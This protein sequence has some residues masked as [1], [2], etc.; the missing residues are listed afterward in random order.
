MAK[1]MTTSPVFNFWVTFSSPK[2]DQKDEEETDLQ[3][4]LISDRG[5][6][7]S[8]FLG[9][10]W[11]QLASCGAISKSLTEADLTHFNLECLTAA[12]EVLNLN[13]NN[14]QSSWFSRLHLEHGLSPRPLLVLAFVRED[15]IPRLPTVSDLQIVP[16]HQAHCMPLVVGP[17]EVGDRVLAVERDDLLGGARRQLQEVHLVAVGLVVD[18]KG[19]GVKLAHPHLLVIGHDGDLVGHGG[20]GLDAGGACLH[21]AVGQDCILGVHSVGVNPVVAAWFG[22]MVCLQGLAVLCWSLLSAI[23]LGEHVE[24]GLQ[25]LKGS[26]HGLALLLR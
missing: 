8:W 24:G 21:V 14:R 26:L 6:K 2:T 23:W 13:I 25:P 16:G 20:L 22:W 5:Q 3:K 19:V 9:L 7:S 10:V 15:R 17:V 4:S 11:V 1:I 12:A 18:I